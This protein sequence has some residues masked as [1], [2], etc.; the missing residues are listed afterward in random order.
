M[1]QTKTKKAIAMAAVSALAVTSIA[2]FSAMN[3]FADQQIG[4]GTIIGG[5]SAAINW[6]E[7]FTAA[8]ASGSVSSVTVKA[9]I[10]PTL[11][12]EIS[13]QEINLGDLVAGNT[14]TG[15]VDIEIGT[16]AAAGVTVTARSGSGGLTNTS[17]N[18]IKLNDDAN[19]PTADGM[20]DSYTFQA[21]A[22]DSDST[23]GGFINNTANDLSAVE[24]N[25]SSEHAV[26]TSNKPEVIDVTKDVRFEVAANPNAQS[27]AGDYEDNI[28]FTVTGNF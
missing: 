28:T 20:A 26:Y 6:N 21:T 23:I 15:S 10:L 4:T 27:A 13:A 22:T 2:G 11:N 19:A 24:I 7:T 9:R 25:S 16:N 17:D 3:V 12:M 18:T 1:T 14:S 8:A 5:N